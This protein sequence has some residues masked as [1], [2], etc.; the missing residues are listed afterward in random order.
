MKKPIYAILA[1]LALAA[2]SCSKSS[3]DD[4]TLSD[5]C[6]ISAFTLGQMQR[7]VSTTTAAGNDT[8]YT[9]AYSGSAFPMTIDQRAQTITM[10]TPLLMNTHLDAVL[11]TVTF[12]GALVHAPENDTTTWAT[13]STTD[14][15]DFT[16]PR[17]YRVVSTDGKSHRDYRVWLTTRSTLA[18]TYTWQR[19]ET[20]MPQVQMI[21]I[22]WAL[23]DEITD[24][25]QIMAE[26]YYV[27]R[28]GNTRLMLACRRNGADATEPLAIWSR[29]L[30]DSDPWTRFDIAPDNPYGLVAPGQLALVSYDNYLMAFVAGSRIIYVSHDNGITWK[31][32]SNLSIP[33]DINL[34]ADDGTPLPMSAMAMGATIWLAVG[35][36]VW[37]LCSNS[38]GEQ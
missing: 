24:N 23:T 14:S 19:S 2:A 6:Y 22:D 27:Q 26:L 38:Y 29:L 20:A 16:T 25:Y 28:N 10:A 8:T 35:S 31:T 13:Y 21:A 33:S 7:S 4:A 1:M 3:D 30:H 9:V 32:D 37:T 18:D 36:D 12:T 17:I 5:N 34:T 11:T 15:V